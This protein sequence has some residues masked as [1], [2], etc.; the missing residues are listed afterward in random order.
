M[1]DRI[2]QLKF[3]NTRPIIS[4]DFQGYKFVASGDRINCSKKWKTFHDFLFDYL[5]LTVG[6]GWGA[7]ELQKDP[8]DR[9]PIIK[10]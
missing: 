9:H 10:W 8:D 2:R 7:G 4:A 3:G 1:N 6:N 5:R